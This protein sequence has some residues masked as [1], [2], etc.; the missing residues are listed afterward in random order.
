MENGKDKRFSY[1][2]LIIAIHLSDIQS[3]DL[4]RVFHEARLLLPLPNRT[5]PDLLSLL[6]PRVYPAVC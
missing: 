6:K 1:F 2:R 5:Q 4:F 3:K